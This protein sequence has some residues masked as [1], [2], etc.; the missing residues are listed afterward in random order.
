MSVI[1]IQNLRFRYEGRA[2]PVFDG[3]T[4]SLDD[5]WRLGLIGRNGRGKTTL[6]KLLAGM[7]DAG[8]AISATARFLYF[9]FSVPDP[10]KT[11]REMLK[12]LGGAEDWRIERELSLLSFRLEALDRPFSTL[13]NGE[14]TKAL[15]AALFL[16]DGAFP[17][18]DE[19]TNH[20][21]LDGRRAVSSYLSKKGG[22]LLVSHDRDFLDRAIDHVL[23]LNPNGAEVLRGNFS[24]WNFERERREAFERAENDKLRGE[25]RRLGEAAR[26]AEAWSGR[27]EKGKH[28]T[29]DSDGRPERGFEGHKAKKL[30]KRA[31]GIEDRRVDAAAEK[32]KL[33]RNVEE[34]EPLK[35]SPEPY[36][37]E[38]LASFENVGAFYDGRAAVRDF[39]LTI[40]SQDRVAL[41][42]GNGSGKTTV[43]KLLTGA[44]IDRTG[45]VRVGSG[46]K[47]SYVP[48]DAS[49]LSGSLPQF[50]EMRGIPA[51]LFLTILRKL[52]FPRAQFEADLSE[53]SDGQKKKALLAA[54]LSERAHLYI[55]DEPLNYVDVFSRMQI[56]E[57]ILEYRPTLLFVEHDR[58]FVER[59][60]TRTVEL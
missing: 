6:L 56:E 53:F 15:L 59:V 1:S 41:V 10:E 20:L 22:F 48:Q 45:A 36:H 14:R 8:G 12:S 31:K 50:A 33:L 3:L 54:S 21:D 39:S 26:R 16:R 42:G 27:A 23:A 55:W 19:P 28:R 25:I 52:G 40:S 18:I 30:M 37:S 51:T 11:A 34:A 35:L 29:S 60:A 32:S 57:L 38:R 9:P 5:A 17:L 24:S 47:I 13:S 58:R 43:L 2:E 7:L 4:L 44:D 49:F 46:L